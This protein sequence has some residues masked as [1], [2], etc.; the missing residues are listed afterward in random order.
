MRLSNFLI[1]QSAYSE[2]YFTNTYWPD[3]GREEFRKALA[4]Y[5]R[6]KRRFGGVLTGSC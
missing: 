6:R 5:A 2:Y 4:T 1:W 3:F